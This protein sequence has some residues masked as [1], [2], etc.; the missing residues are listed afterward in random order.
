MGPTSQTDETTRISP[1]ATADAFP[2]EQ[3]N[4]ASAVTAIVVVLVVTAL[5]VLLL[6]VLIIGIVILK[7]KRSKTFSPAQYS[8]ETVDMNGMQH[9]PLY[10]IVVVKKH[11]SS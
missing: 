6:V 2:D 3:Q 4:G 8:E 7:V 1:P 11:S 9:E 5:V 10:Y